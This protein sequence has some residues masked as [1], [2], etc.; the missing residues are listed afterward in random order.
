VTLNCPCGAELIPGSLATDEYLNA[1]RA[2]HA[3]HK[4]KKETET[5]MANAVNREALQSKGGG[6]VFAPPSDLAKLIIREE[7]PSHPN[8]HEHM[9]RVDPNDPENIALARSFRLHGWPDSQNISCWKDGNGDDAEYPL[10]NGRRRL[11]FVRL[12]NERRTRENDPRGLIRPRVVLDSNPLLTE[13]IANS[14]HKDDPPMVRARRYV[15]LKASG[16]SALEAAA[17]LGL[18]LEHAQ[19]LAAVNGFGGVEAVD[20]QQAVNEKIIPADVAARAVKAGSAAV[21]K[22]VEAVKEAKAKAPVDKKGKAAKKAA[23]K[24]AKDIPT[25]ARAKN[26]VFLQLVADQ[27]EASDSGVKVVQ[28]LRWAAGD[29]APGWLTKY[30]DAAKAEK[31][32]KGAKGK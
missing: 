26:A 9:I 21:K 1:W 20:L 5:D 27:L 6:D 32:K 8:Y 14:M 16:M 3:G 15:A 18:D 23:R 22:V 28:A 10:S 17:A 29:E 25:H 24:A 4:T 12:E 30:I 31:T 19:H 13:T 11:T 2:E 7:N